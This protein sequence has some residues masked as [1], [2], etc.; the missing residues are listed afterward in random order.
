MSSIAKEYETKAKRLA[1]VLKEGKTDDPQK[2]DLE[3][4]SSLSGSQQEKVEEIKRMKT[5]VEM[6]GLQVDAFNAQE[7][8]RKAIERSQHPVGDAAD[9]FALKGEQPTA[10]D[11]F[12]KSTEF[13]NRSSK[14]AELAIDARSWLYGEQKTIMTTAAGWATRPAR[15]AE[16]TP[17]VYRPLQV[18]DVI[19]SSNTDAT[20][21]IYME[22]TTRTNAAI[23]IGEGVAYPEATSA[24]TERTSPVRKIGVILPVTD[25]QL[26]D[27]PQVRTFLDDLLPFMIRQRLDQQIFNGNGTPPNLTGLLN[28]GSI[29]TQAKGADP[30]PTAFLKAIVKVRVTGRAVPSATL[31][32]PTDWQSVKTLTTADGIYIW[33]NPA[34]TGPDT[35]W[36]LPMVQVDA[37][38]AGTAVVADFQ[39]YTRLYYRSA[40][41]GVEVGYVNDDFKLGQKSLRA[42]VRA[43]FV[44]RRPAAVCTVTGL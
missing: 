24:F 39:N 19:P 33:G 2:I 6:L 12:L 32:H 31:I 21:I 37:G 40:P 10:A 7:A 30:I 13:K 38:S 43:A 1:D 5:E 9:A 14:P 22:E 44:V 18:T 16:F 42:D 28:V 8:A 26:E 27:V 17:I 34:L 25:E 4:V 11:M 41:S 29:Q 20:S 36:G 23:E 3:K 15:I 35:M